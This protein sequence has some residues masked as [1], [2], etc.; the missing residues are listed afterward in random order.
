[1]NSET[2]AC[3]F[4]GRLTSVSVGISSI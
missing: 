4:E 3:V 1:L 2:A